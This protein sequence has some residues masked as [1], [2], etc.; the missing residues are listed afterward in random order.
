MKFTYYGQSCFEI[1][2]GGKKLLFDP[3]ITYNPLAKDIDVSSLKP[4][5]ILVSHGHGDHVADLM[6]VQKQ[7]G[8]KVICIAEIADWLG[9]QEIEAHGMNIGG[10][11]NFDF[12]R[13]KMVNAVHSST[14][15][16]GSPGGSPAGFVVYAEGKKIYFAG[17]TALT[18]DMKLLADE[19]LD[20]A[21]LPIGDN[22]TMGVDD[23]I[24]STGFFDCKNVIG[25][26]YDSFPVIVI[27]K[28]E[29]L[30]KFT[31]AGIKLELPVIGASLEL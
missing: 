18:Y 29:A 17:D 25:V 16:D 5:Y 26:H 11:F 14:L 13:V 8:A 1:E 30:D 24:K 12:G 15:P 31:K 7:S 2:T 22:Y 28:E 20:W 3:F 19:K 10:G 21:I 4:D 27:D 9:K 6:T 23:A